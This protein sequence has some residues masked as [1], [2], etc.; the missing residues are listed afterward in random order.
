MQLF[1]RRICE[2][3]MQAGTALLKAA[4]DITVEQNEH[5]SFMPGKLIA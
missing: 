4:P 2:A 1:G 5:M 3:L